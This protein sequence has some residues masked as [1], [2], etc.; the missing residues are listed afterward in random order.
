MQRKSG[1]TL[2]EIMIVVAIIGL[3]A[4]IAVPSLLKARQETQKK[5]IT[6]NLRLIED[7]RD[8]V[9]TV[10]NFTAYT[11]VSAA[12]IGPFLKAG[13]IGKMNWPDT[14]EAVIPAG[15]VILK[16]AADTSLDDWVHIDPMEVE[17]T[18]GDTT[19]TLR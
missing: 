11:S 15:N 7:G 2:V 13:E 10:S 9:M 6:N 3:L 19:E 8:Q 1:F 14:A 4:A 18:F 16:D 17:I 5:L 12:M